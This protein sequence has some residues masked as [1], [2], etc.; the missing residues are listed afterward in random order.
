MTDSVTRSLVVA[1]PQ[2]RVW[3]AVSDHREFGAWFRAELSGPFEEGAT[4]SGA[5]TGEAAGMP[6]DARILTV[7]PESLLAFDWPAY[8]RED[9]VLYDEPWTRVEF[10]LEAEGEGTRVTV[11]ESGFDRLPERVRTAARDGNDEGWRVQL[12]NLAAFAERALA[13]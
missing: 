2:G 3:R 13:V 6:F 12:L 5:M 9:G 11:T 7:R 10:R 4:I 8:T 1:A